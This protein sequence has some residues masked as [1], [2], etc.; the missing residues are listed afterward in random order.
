M[1]WAAVIVGGVSLAGSAVQASQA[2]KQMNQAKLMDTQDPGYAG[3]P[4]LRANADM[5]Q[6]RFLNYNI[7]NYQAALEG[8]DRASE[9]A[10]R[11]ATQGAT[12]SSDLIDAATKI[13]YGGQVASRDLNVQAGI[14]RDQAFMDYI[15]ANQLAGED[16][17][18]SNE[19]E[20]QGF[21]R[22]QQHAANLENASISNTWNA[23]QGGLNTAAQLGTYAYRNGAFGGSNNITNSQS[24]NTVLPGANLQAN[25]N[26]L[27]PLDSRGVNFVNP[28]LPK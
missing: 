19:W 13:A 9:M 14:G 18:R 5:L 28:Y 27:I 20:R 10:Y 6:N 7:P 11:S 12:S 1:S 22:D 3:N 15:S 16:I 4:E 25:P 21:L 23:I 17:A 26:T 24:I 8:I 2:S